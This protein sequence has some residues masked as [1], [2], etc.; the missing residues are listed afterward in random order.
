M[1]NLK[2]CIVAEIKKLSPGRKVYVVFQSSSL[3]FSF[4]TI[5]YVS[6]PQYD[7]YWLD[8]KDTARPKS[9][10]HE[11]GLFGQKGELLRFSMVVSDC[12]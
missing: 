7:T 9:G 10:V 2:N 8:F 5:D 6:T 11:F 4:I 12:K 1:T 3:W